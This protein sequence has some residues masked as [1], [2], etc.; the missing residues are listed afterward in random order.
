[1]RSFRIVT[2]GRCFK[3]QEMVDGLW[4]DVTPPL[5]QKSDAEKFIAAQ[6]QRDADAIGPWEPA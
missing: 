1:M 5:G 4:R 2:N 3:A 6:R